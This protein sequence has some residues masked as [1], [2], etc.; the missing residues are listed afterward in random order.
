MIS[1]YVKKNKKTS[2]VTFVTKD[3]FC[4]LQT[5]LLNK[6]ASIY[7]ED[8]K[9]YNDIFCNSLFNQFIGFF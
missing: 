5:A 9:L 4:L 6:N 7:S 8:L 1:Q 2:F 3:V